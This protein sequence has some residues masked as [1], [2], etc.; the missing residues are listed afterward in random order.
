[1]S[2]RKKILFGIV[3]ML[4]ASLMAEE[5]LADAEVT[6]RGERAATQF[7][8][9]VVGDNVEQL[10]KLLRQFSRDA[11]Y[12]YRFDEKSDAIV[13]SVTCNDLELV[14]FADA[15]GARDVSRYLTEYTVVVEEV[16]L[17]EP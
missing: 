11:L 1:M 14:E 16:V 2:V 9:A 10:E 7:C 4:P 13:R 17:G 6:Y 12:R 8:Q 5:F 15:I 3:A